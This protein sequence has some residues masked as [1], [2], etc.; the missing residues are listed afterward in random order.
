MDLHGT[1]FEGRAWYRDA[2]ESRENGDGHCRVTR[3]MKLSTGPEVIR[4]A[5]ARDGVC[6][7][8]MYV[9]YFVFCILYFVL[10]CIVLYFVF[11]ILYFVF[12]ILY[13]VFCILYCI[14]L[15]FVFCI[16]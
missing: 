16:L 6:Q 5:W 7:I 15:Y 1:F 2:G 13:F 9:L 10:Y 4:M 12:C 3:C 14:V 11:C 8:Y